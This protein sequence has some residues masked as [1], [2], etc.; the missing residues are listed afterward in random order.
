M[1]INDYLTYYDVTKAED[2][3]FEVASFLGGWFIEKCL[4]SSRNSL[5]KTTSSVKKFYQY[6]SE[7]NYISV[8]NYKEM[9]RYIKD[10]MDEMLKRV[11]K[12]NEE[13]YYDLF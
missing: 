11:D 7:S 13:I 9:C 3:V 12:Y 1:F 10:N 5:K 4:W 8:E 2:G 6:M